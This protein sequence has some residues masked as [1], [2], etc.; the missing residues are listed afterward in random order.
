MKLETVEEIGGALDHFL[1]VGI[2]HPCR[3][4]R[5]MG[6]NPRWGDWEEAGV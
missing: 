6:G 5:R 4:A 3:L 1:E 2:Y